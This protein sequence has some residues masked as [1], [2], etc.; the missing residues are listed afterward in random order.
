[1]DELIEKVNLVRNA[2]GTLNITSNRHNLDVLLG[3]M[4][5]LDEVVS[6]M[7]ELKCEYNGNDRRCENGSNP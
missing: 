3:S 5:V 2:L 6:A 1:M 4:R 7:E